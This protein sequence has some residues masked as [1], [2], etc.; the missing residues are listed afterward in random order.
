MAPGQRPQLFRQGKSD[1][2]I[3]SRKLFLNLPFDPLLALMMLTM[4]TVSVTAGM[5]YKSLMITIATTHEHLG[6]VP[7]STGLQGHECFLMTG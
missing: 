2:K 6:A 4:W 3:R 1:H 5:R 7:G